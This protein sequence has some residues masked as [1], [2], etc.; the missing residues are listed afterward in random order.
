MR[1]FNPLFINTLV[2]FLLLAFGT[3][4]FAQLC[5]DRVQPTKPASHFEM[6]NVDNELAFDEVKDTVT[7]LIWKRCSVGQSWVD[8]SCSGTATTHTWSEALALETG[9]WR[10]PNVHELSSLAEAACLAPAIDLTVFPNTQGDYYWS[11]SPYAKSKKSAWY[12]DFTW[13]EATA[14]NTTVKF[15]NNQTMKHFLYVRL[16]RDAE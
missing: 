8:T 6:P 13:G 2:S 10:L 15:F 3:D 9:E 12:I 11:S 16:V 4:S 1:Q 14:F 7:E 5:N